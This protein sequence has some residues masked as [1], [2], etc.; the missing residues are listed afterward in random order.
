MRLPE[1]LATNSIPL[2]YCPV[3]FCS[4]ECEELAAV[5]ATH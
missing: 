2:L 5:S 3:L 4:I 1:F